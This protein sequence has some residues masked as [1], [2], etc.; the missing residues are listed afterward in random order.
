MVGRGERY[1]RPN[2]FN[3]YSP[4]KQSHQIGLDTFMGS[5]Y[6]SDWNVLLHRLETESGERVFCIW[7]WTK[8]K[9]LNRNILVS[10]AGRENHQ[11][12]QHLLNE[13]RSYFDGRHY[14]EECWICGKG[15]ACSYCLKFKK[16]KYKDISPSYR[17]CKTIFF[18]S[19]FCFSW[20]NQRKKKLLDEF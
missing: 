3:A 1:G 12:I 4:Q 6:R 20:L 5:H 7:M 15:Y 18:F 10:S 19:Y 8:I 16:I 13:R 17:N 11:G 2:H 9:R 14:I